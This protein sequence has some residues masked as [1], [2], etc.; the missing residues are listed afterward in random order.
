MDYL[1][2]NLPRN[3]H[4]LQGQHSYTSIS[5]DSMHAKDQ[6][7]SGCRTPQTVSHLN[8][9]VYMKAEFDQ[10]SSKQLN[11]SVQWQSYFT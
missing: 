7:Q 8:F 1:I 3:L 2:Q 9:S 5:R 6:I 11:N 10:V 4:S